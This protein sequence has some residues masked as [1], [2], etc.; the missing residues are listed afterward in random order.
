MQPHKE[1][2]ARAILAHGGD[3]LTKMRTFRETA[4]MRGSGP[5]GMRTPSQQSEVWLDYPARCG[6]WQMRQGTK[7]LAIY[8][9][10]PEG[11]FLSTPKT[12]A[13]KIPKIEQ[14]EKTFDFLPLIKTGVLGLLTL[15]TT[16]DSVTFTEKGEIKGRRGPM[17]VRTQIAPRQSLLL[18]GRDGFASEPCQ[19]TWSYLFALDGTL[20]AEQITQTQPKRITQMQ[21]SYDTFRMFGGIKIP[22]EIS[23]KSNLVP[24]GFSLG[25]RVTTVAINENLSPP[26]FSENTL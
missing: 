13:Q 15:Q 17:I 24:R 20:I 14:A 9:Q 4:E 18:L 1:L 26:I 21:L 5:L 6:R 12:S 7:T 2:L 11:I 8:Q 22:T 16:S 19:T 10:T 3:A 23:I 25:I